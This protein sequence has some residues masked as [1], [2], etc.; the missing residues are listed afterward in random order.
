MRQHLLA[1]GAMAAIGLPIILAG[2]CL[3]FVVAKSITGLD[4]TQAPLE[5]PRQAMAYLA[6][7]IGGSRL[8]TFPALYLWLWFLR[9]KISPHVVYH[10]LTAGPQPPGLSHLA[11][12]IFKRVYG[13]GVG[14]GDRAV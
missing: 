5:T 8:A 11:R 2:G 3:G 9:G 10:W 13:E 7:T 1:F 12:R 6:F 4:W 14:P